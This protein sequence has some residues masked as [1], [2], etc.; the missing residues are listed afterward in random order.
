[1]WTSRRSRSLSFGCLACRHNNYWWWGPPQPSLGSAVFV[2]HWSKPYLETMFRSATLV[3]HI[4]NP[5]GVSNDE[6]GAE[7]WVCR[8]QKRPW[9]ALWP[10]FKSYG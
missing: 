1:M 5:F 3:A 7:V 2:G 9:P 8:G 10:Q 6:W 4:H